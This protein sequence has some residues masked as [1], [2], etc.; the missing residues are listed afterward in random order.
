MTP[1]KILF[2]FCISFVAGIFAESSFGIAQDKIVKI[3]QIFLWGFLFLAITIIFTSLILA[4]SLRKRGSRIWIP[5]F[6][7]MTVAGFCV[8][9]FTIGVLRVQISEFN[10]E[11]NQ[12]RKLNDK[13][14]ITLVGAII[15]EPDVRDNSQKI[16]IEIENP[17]EVI[18]VTTSRYPEYKYLDKIKIT[19]KLET[20]AETEDF[21][22]KNYCYC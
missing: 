13:G 2:Y 21:S 9:F 5:F 18:L 22:Y 19:G 10:I 1:S 12:L 17:M 6:K 15:K 8:L 4:S 16:K 14:K 20:P 3:P 11:N 7:G